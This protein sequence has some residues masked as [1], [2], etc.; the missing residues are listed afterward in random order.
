M[1]DKE[2]YDMEY[3]CFNCNTKFISPVIKVMQ[4][5]GA[6]GE[7]PYCGV[8]DCLDGGGESTTHIVLGRPILD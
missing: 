5:D 7:C 8:K 4:A 2:T 1:T 6:A 3:Q